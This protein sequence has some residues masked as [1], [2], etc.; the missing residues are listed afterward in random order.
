MRD[1][2]NILLF[3][4]V[5]NLNRGTFIEWNLADRYRGEIPFFKSLFFDKIGYF[6]NAHEHYAARQDPDCFLVV[7]CTEGKGYLKLEHQTY[8]I[9][10]GMLF[11]TYP[12]LPHTYCADRENP[13]SIYW[14]H[15]FVGD[16]QI[17]DIM[18]QN[19]IT[20]KIPVMAD[21]DYTQLKEGFQRILTDRYHITI[22]GLRYRQSIF[23]ELMF[24]I[25]YL[26]SQVER[27]ESWMDLVVEYIHDHLGEPLS[28]DKIAESQH[29]S[30]YYLSHR[31]SME[32]GISIRQ[33]I[34]E[35]RINQ[36]K[37]LLLSTKMNIR[38]IS[39]LCGYENSMYFSNAFKAKTGWSP[40][41]YREKELE[42]K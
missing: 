4:E 20:P 41:A 30:K 21:L 29:V 34:M 3:L 40:S 32:Q 35:A 31:F 33:Y 39:E 17:K 42:N 7:L 8:E 22:Q 26:H 25:F 13:W 18:E 37:T 2:Y 38:E 10:K 28:L 27:K 12:H 6:K 24:K 9:R 23:T 1:F 14:A 19:G 16:S 15:F 11:F 5:K 36:A